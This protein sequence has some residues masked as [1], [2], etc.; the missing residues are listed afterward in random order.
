PVGIGAISPLDPSG[1]G[2]RQATTFL[3]HFAV[4]QSATGTYSYAVGPGV[5]DLVGPNRGS[6][7]AGN[8]IGPHAHAHTAQDPGRVYPL[9]GP[10]FCPPC[11]PPPLPSIVPGPH[12]VT[13]DAVIGTPSPTAS[14]SAS[15]DN[16]VTNDTVGA[17]DV[18]F[19]R[20]MIVASFTPGQVLRMVGP[21]GP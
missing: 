19:D 10:P 1:P 20:D 21:A 17:V 13:T 16:L 11:A 18:T 2:G 12:V 9:P 3:V 5:S 8:P 7:G 4:P 6:G 14:V 15:A